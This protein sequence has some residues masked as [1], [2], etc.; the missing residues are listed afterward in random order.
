MQLFSV[1]LPRF[2]CLAWVNFDSRSSVFGFSGRSAGKHALLVGMWQTWHTR[3][4]LFTP[5]TFTAAHDV[6]NVWQPPQRVCSTTL[7]GSP[8]ALSLWQSAHF[9]CLRPAD[10]AA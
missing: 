3:A 1:E 5:V 4:G 6:G 2:M 7:V 10:D 8:C 9:A